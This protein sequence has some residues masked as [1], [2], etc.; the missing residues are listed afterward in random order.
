M[1][2]HQCGQ[3]KQ[4]QQL[5]TKKDKMQ[6]YFKQL[7]ITPSA[8][9]GGKNNIV[10]VIDSIDPDYVFRTRTYKDGSMI[11]LLKDGHEKTEKRDF[12]TKNGVDASV[13]EKVW[14][15]TEIMLD[16]KDAL[17]FRMISEIIV[18]GVDNVEEQEVIAS[19][20]AE[21]IEKIFKTGGGEDAAGAELLNGV[22]EEETQQAA[23][24]E[25]EKLFSVEEY[26]VPPVAEET[27][28]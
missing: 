27:T 17:R 7:Q 26:P 24:K 19:V 5:K 3:Q 25:Y 6:F 1:K 18:S 14:V 20:G 2:K 23:K 10:T 28:N 13:N 11:I 21:D 8:E 16:P 12:K 9:K 15:Q 4:L 22:T